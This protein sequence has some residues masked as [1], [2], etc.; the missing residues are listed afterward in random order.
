MPGASALIPLG[1]GTDYA[2]SLTTGYSDAVDV[3]A[4]LLCDPEGGQPQLD[5]NGYMFKG[6]C[7][8]MESRDET[9]THQTARQRTRGP[10]GMETHTF[11][12]T[13]HGPV[14]Q[15]G[16]VEG[17]AGR[18]REGAVLLEE[19]DSTRF[20]SSIS[21]NTQVDSLDDFKDAAKDFTMSFNAFYA[22][23]EAHRLLPRRPL[24][25]A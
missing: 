12:R 6:E 21:W 22:D 15:R 19:G 5:S 11:Y 14:F 16:T 1:R 23:S 4:E 25:D 3:R 8:E 13:N 7:K 18:I 24:P 17:Q 20:L 9:F 2:W 10:P